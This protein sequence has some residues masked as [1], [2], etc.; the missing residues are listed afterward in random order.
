MVGRV[1][2][3]VKTV[4]VVP[5]N[6]ETTPTGATFQALPVVLYDSVYKIESFESLVNPRLFEN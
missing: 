6:E 5:E 3:E 4:I 1:P 2:S